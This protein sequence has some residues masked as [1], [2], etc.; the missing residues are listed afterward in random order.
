MVG[1][2]DADIRCR[3]R[4]DVGDD[5]V[6]DLSVIGIQFQIDFDIRIDRFKIGDRLLVD[7]DLID[8]GIV[9]RPERDLIGL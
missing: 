9:L 8:V 3:I 5:I 2:G 6:I 7:V 4:R 1:I